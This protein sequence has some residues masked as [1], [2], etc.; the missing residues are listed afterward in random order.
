VQNNRN[1]YDTGC[2]S[3]DESFVASHFVHRQN[4]YFAFLNYWPKRYLVA[5][6]FFAGK[7]LFPYR[8]TTSGCRGEKAIV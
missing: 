4:N 1:Y 5:F 2:R 6:V 8:Q 7:L 3:S